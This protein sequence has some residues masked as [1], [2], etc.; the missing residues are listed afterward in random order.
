MT[1]TL[2]QAYGSGGTLVLSESGDE[3]TTDGYTIVYSVDG[4]PERPAV[5]TLSER[6]LSWS[7]SVVEGDAIR[8]AF[9]DRFVK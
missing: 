1:T 3:F 6:G 5:P 7:H 8:R 4:I 9:G 2:I